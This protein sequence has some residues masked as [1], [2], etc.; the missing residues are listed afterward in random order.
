MNA[1][2]W[3]GARRWSA[4]YAPF[5]IALVATTVVGSPEAR[6]QVHW[7]I[8]VQAG[9]S[10]RFTTG[11]PRVPTPTPGPRGELLAHVAIL[12]MLRAGPYAAFDLSPAAGIP[13]RQTYAVGLRA[14]LTPP[15]LAAPWHA[16]AFLGA[17]FADSYTPSYRPASDGVVG[18]SSTGMLELPVGIGIGHKLHGPW[19]L[20][21]E[22]GARVVVARGSIHTGSNS[23]SGE[24]APIASEDL[25]AVSVSLGVSLVQ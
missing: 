17:G 12:P 4:T 1:G 25:L 9:A 7:D 20:C 10:E 11:N 15:W 21:A 13:A 6:A 19:E 14:K 23:G 18:S 16:W 2:V 22:L 8:G 24:V 3:S 5:A